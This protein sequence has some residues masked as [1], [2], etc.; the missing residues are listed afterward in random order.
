MRPTDSGVSN[1]TVKSA[2]AQTTNR[3]YLSEDCIEENGTGRNKLPNGYSLAKSQRRESEA[4]LKQVLATR[5]SINDARQHRPGSTWMF[6]EEQPPTQRSEMQGLTLK[7][8]QQIDMSVLDVIIGTK[9]FQQFLD[10]CHDGEDTKDWIK[11]FTTSS[12]TVLY[13]VKVQLW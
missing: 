12:W 4:A 13:A 1:M 8:N 3:C 7:L 11:K 5:K 10:L 9:R 6:E 2:R